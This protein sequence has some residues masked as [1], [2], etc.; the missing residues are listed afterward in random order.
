MITAPV[1]GRLSDKYPAGLLCGV[2]L[3]VL[4]TGLMLMFS[5]PPDASLGQVAWRM[6]WCG[7]GFG[8]FQSSNVRAIVSAAPRN[9]SGVASGMMSTARLTGQTIGGVVVAMTFGFMHGDI[10]GG[11]HVALTVAVVLSAVASVLSF[12][13]LR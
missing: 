8:F 9:R 10:A 4:T 7:I 12:L 3:V 1:S 11:V 6:A 5:V 2:G 13:R